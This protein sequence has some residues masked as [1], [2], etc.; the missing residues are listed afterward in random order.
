MINLLLVRHGFIQKHIGRDKLDISR[1]LP[2]WGSAKKSWASVE[3]GE[4]T[5]KQYWVNISS[6]L[7]LTF[8][9]CSSDATLW[10]VLCLNLTN[11]LTWFSAPWLADL[12]IWTNQE[13]MMWSNLFVNSIQVSDHFSLSVG[14]S[15]SFN[16]L[17]CEDL[18]NPGIRTYKFVCKSKI[19]IYS[20]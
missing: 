10:C 8:W 5:L 13:V 7:G 14:G 11:N 1:T 15:T 3:D 12:A 17:C 18:Q 20:Y 9:V 4:P 6:L 19:K 16:S 2:R